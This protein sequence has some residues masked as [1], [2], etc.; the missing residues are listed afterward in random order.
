MLCVTVS[1]TN[2]LK[3]SPSNPCNPQ[4]PTA[5]A[6]PTSLQAALPAFTKSHSKFSR[7]TLNQ[8]SHPQQSQ[9]GS[10]A[11][12]QAQIPV[13]RGGLQASQTQAQPTL[14]GCGRRQAL[15][16]RA[17]APAQRGRLQPGS[18]ASQTRQQ[19]KLEGQAN[20]SAQA[21]LDTTAWRVVVVEVSNPK[22]T[23]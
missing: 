11:Q 3:K 15:Q 22:T 23:S 21:E 20:R 10:K 14:F 8:S 2:I 6:P 17:Q 7:S 12:P 9:P 16:P 19:L 18:Q 5:A 1:I 13:L 4:S